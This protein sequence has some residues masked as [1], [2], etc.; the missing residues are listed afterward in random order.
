MIQILI[1][2]SQT[3]RLPSGRRVPRGGSGLFRTD[4]GGVVQDRSVQSLREGKGLRDAFQASELQRQVLR[5]AVQA[6][7]G[8][9]ASNPCS[10]SIP[11]LPGSKRSSLQPRRIWPR[12]RKGRQYRENRSGAG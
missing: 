12:E 11:G 10:S 2:G 3:V 4:R 9:N 6:S 7:D 5:G 8:T 1:A